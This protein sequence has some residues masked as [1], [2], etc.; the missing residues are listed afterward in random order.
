M[1]SSQAKQIQIVDFLAA[2]GYMPTVLKSNDYWYL[3]PLREEKS[4]S[5]K[6]NIN[7][8]VWYDHGAGKG[9]TIIDLVRQLYQVDTVE[10][11]ALL[12][13]KRWSVANG[14]IMPIRRPADFN[15]TKGSKSG[16]VID[17]IR[18]LDRSAL[19]HYLESR[20]VSVEIGRTYLYECYYRIQGRLSRGQRQY[21]GLAFQNDLGGFELRHKLSKCSTSPKAITTINPGRSTIAVFEGFFDMLSAFVYYKKSKSTHSIIVLN[22]VSLLESAMPALKTY[23]RVNLFLDN[24]SAGRKAVES[25]QQ[26]HSNVTDYSRMIY[27]NYKDFNDFLIN[28]QRSN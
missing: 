5:F 15:A 28:E 24:D 23:G 1:N 6:V 2:M 11:L 21:F 16:I 22:S 3:S 8:N 12:S 4:S 18:T 26:N 20:G 13:R 14:S 25:I 17:S 10:A 19:T 9:G 27:P 7:R